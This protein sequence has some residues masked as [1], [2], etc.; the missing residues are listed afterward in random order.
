MSTTSHVTARKP[1]YPFHFTHFTMLA[2][3]L[4]GTRF[5]LPTIRM[6]TTETQDVEPTKTMEELTK[7]NEDLHSRNLFL[8][9][10][11]EN[12]HRRFSRLATEIEKTAAMEIGRAVLPV[13]DNLKRVSAAGDKQDV[14]AILDAVDMIDSQFHAVLK[15]FSIQRMSSLRAKFDPAFQDASA[16]VDTGKAEDCGVV[17]DVISEGYMI[18][19]KVL[20]AAKVVVGK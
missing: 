9:A 18:S 6:F 13:I 12:A 7:E 17:I 3:V 8:L 15:Q 1:L 20:R 16:E 11:V 14:K 19:D 10:D 5:S 2:R 4:D